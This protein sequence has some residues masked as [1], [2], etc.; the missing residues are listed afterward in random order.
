MLVSRSL[1]TNF[2]FQLTAEEFIHFWVE[3]DIE[4][5]FDEEEF[6]LRLGNCCSAE[7]NCCFAGGGFN[8]SSVDVFLSKGGSPTL[9]MRLFVLAVATSS[10]STG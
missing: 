4:L 5:Y 9:L 10:T 6:V 2:E 7:G 8:A 3:I 1:S